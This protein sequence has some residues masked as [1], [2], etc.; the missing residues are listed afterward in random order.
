MSRIEA[1]PVGYLR[2]SSFNGAAPGTEDLGNLSVSDSV[3]EQH[4]TRAA[5]SSS[6]SALYDSVESYVE[7]CQG[8]KVI[9]KVLIANNGIGYLIDTLGEDGDLAAMFS[10]VFVISAIGFCA[11]R[12]FVAFTRYLLRWRETDSEIRA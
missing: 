9:K 2:S 4:N 1:D 5:S 8:K 6:I 10:A 12:L 11:D 7:V 3:R